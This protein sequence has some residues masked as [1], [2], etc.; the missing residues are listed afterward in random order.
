MVMQ[1]TEALPVV[2]SNPGRVNTAPP[3]TPPTVSQ[4]GFEP[5][6]KN[7]APAALPFDR[8]LVHSDGLPHCLEPDQKLLTP[9]STPPPQKS[10]IQF[11]GIDASESK[12]PL[13]DGLIGQN[14]DFTRGWTSNIM[15]WG[16][17]R[18]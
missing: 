1:L 9:H 2:G 4:P 12:N 8:Q 3:P 15:P 10:D 16:M 5:P 6:T 17:L 13:G 18:E 14:N 11:Q 7:F